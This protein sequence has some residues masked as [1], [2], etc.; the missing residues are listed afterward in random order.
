MTDAAYRAEQQQ[1]QIEN[2]H[3]IRENILKTFLFFKATN[4]FMVYTIYGADK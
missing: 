1:F 3:R 2:Q 4:A